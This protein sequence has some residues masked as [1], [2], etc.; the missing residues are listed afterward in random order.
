MGEFDRLVE[1]KEAKYLI[2]NTL[3][4]N[5]ISKIRCKTVL[6]GRR[7]EVEF[8]NLGTVPSQHDSM[9]RGEREQ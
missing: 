5:K 6:G 3:Q 4:R 9:E 7:L 8:K 2:L 1:R